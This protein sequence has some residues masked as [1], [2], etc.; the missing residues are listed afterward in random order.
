M[1]L[2]AE[3]FV[4]L[5]FPP[6]KN[7]PCLLFSLSSPDLDREVCAFT[8]ACARIVC[9]LCDPLFP[10][11][12]SEVFNAPTSATGKAIPNPFFQVRGK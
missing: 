8:S 12:K 10:D 7:R 11:C 2:L 9:G 5:V 4:V 3:R 6:L 1:I